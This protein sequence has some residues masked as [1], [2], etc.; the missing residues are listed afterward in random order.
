MT[1]MLTGG[2]GYIGSHTCVELIREGHSIIIFDNFC[3][4]QME[5]LN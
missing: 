2:A 4:S 1:V 5:V 3:N